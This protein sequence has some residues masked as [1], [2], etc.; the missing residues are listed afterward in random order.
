[1]AIQQIETKEVKGTQGGQ[2]KI[3]E[4]AVGMI[5]DIVQ[6]Q[7]Y[8]KPFEST[9]RELTAN[10]IE[11][12]FKYAETSG[13]GTVGMK[14]TLELEKLGDRRNMKKTVNKGNYQHVHFT[15]LSSI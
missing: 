14:V 1:M 11:G 5:M 8:T 7:Q 6:V 12:A 9:V 10:A 15:L 3:N 4:S 2:R 13:Y